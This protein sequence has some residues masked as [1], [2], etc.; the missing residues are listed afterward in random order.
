MGRLDRSV[1]ELSEAFDH[2]S[3]EI[4][5]LQAA[6]MAMRSGLFPPGQ[7]LNALLESFVIH[8][9]ALLHFLD[10]V[11]PAKGDVLAVDFILDPET[12]EAAKGELPKELIQVRQ[13]ANKHVAHMTYDRLSVA[14]EA[15]S[16]DTGAISKELTVRLVEFVRYMRPDVKA[17]LGIAESQS[18]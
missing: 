11:S 12:W 5:M 6:D 9:R 17:A 15:R 10:P 4:D 18:G 2:L 3:Y 16:W 1:Q 13:R 7:L 8:A 14:D